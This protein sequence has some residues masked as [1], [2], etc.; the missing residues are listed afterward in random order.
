MHRR[1]IPASQ[2]YTPRCTKRDGFPKIKS[3]LPHKID[4]AAAQKD[5]NFQSGCDPPVCNSETNR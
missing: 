5:E 4:A 1:K 2:L 3:A